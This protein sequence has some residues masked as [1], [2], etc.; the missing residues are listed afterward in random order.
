MKTD[1]GLKYLVATDTDG[2]STITEVTRLSDNVTFKKGDRV[3]TPNGTVDTIKGFTLYEKNSGTIITVSLRPQ[4]D[5]GYHDR[6]G[7]N[8]QMVQHVNDDYETGYAAG[9]QAAL[10]AMQQSLKTLY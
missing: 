7:I 9:Y 5:S 2:E 6:T 8:I 10:E 3:S 4:F 1:K